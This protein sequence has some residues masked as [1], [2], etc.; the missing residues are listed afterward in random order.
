MHEEV[1]L[2]SL[3]ASAR[4]V[5][6]AF[7]HETRNLCSAMRVLVSALMQRPGVAETEE[8][9]GLKSLVDSLGWRTRSCTPLPSTDLI[10]PASGRRSI[11]YA[12]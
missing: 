12:L 3:T 7:W 4:I 6:G 10:V 5:M 2:R 8:V 1:G 9:E 11:N